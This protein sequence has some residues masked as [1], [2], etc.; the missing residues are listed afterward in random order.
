MDMDPLDIVGTSEPCNCHG[1][2]DTCNQDTGVCV[3]S[4]L[5]K[6]RVEGILTFTCPKSLVNTFAS[7]KAQPVG[8]LRLYQT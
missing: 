2:S 8:L 1:H 5:L 3:V 7:P 4:V 6:T